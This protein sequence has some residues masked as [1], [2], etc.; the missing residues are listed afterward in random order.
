MTKRNCWWAWGC[1]AM[2][3]AEALPEDWIKD[4]ANV[5]AYTLPDP[6]TAANGDRVATAAA[7]TQQRRPELLKFFEEHVYGRTPLGKPAGMAWRTLRET[8]VCG[9][10][11]VRREIEVRL[12]GAAR[13]PLLLN[14]YLPIGNAKAPVILGLNFEGNAAA[15]ADPKLPLP[16]YSPKP[17]Y[18]GVKQP[19]TE[20]DRGTEASRWRIDLALKAGVGVATAWYFDFE[21]DHAQGFADGIRAQAGKPVGPGDWGAIGAW[22]WGMSRLLDVLETEPG[23]DAKRIVAFGHSRLGKTALWAAAQDQRFAAAISNN[24]GAGGAALSRRLFGERTHHL[25]ERF[26]HWFCKNCQRYSRNE[27]NCPVDQHELL[28]LL[29]PRPLLVTSAAEDLWADPKGE[30]LALHH[31]GPVYQ[32]FGHKGLPAEQPPGLGTLLN[33]RTAYFIRP[34]KHDVTADDWA[35]YLKF[36][37]KHLP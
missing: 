5:P 18:Q 8:P 1:L 27:V 26:P 35:A 33:Q 6:L 24:S 16:A 7:W 23:V 21:P 12:F 29:A 2:A 13:P 34:G 3:A 19:A 25:N 10:T 4:E 15:D 32:L 22:A 28:A 17:A 30:Y 37:A 14:L 9:G 20:K 36:V 11:G 31:A